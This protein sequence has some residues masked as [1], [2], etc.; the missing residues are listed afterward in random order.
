ML[1]PFILTMEF[2]LAC[3]RTYDT[4]N[5]RLLN[6]TYPYHAYAGTYCEF[7]IHVPNPEA[8]IS[9]YFKYFYVSSRGNCTDEAYLKVMELDLNTLFSNFKTLCSSRLINC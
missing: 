1:I 2:L 4:D 5:G 8:K 6:P 9:L 3:N 7:G